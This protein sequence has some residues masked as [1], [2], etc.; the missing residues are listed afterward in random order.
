DRDGARGAYENAARLAP[1]DVAVQRKVVE[2]NAEAP[3][4]WRESARA[5]AAEWQLRP[6]D[7]E[8]GGRLV[9]LFLKAGR[10]DAAAV[11]AGAMVLRGVADQRANALAAGA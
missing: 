11:A 2:H 3:G 7:A 9:D 4:R 8:L 6:G 1:G 5:L 10:R